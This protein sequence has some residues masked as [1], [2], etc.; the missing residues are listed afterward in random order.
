MKAY[1]DSGGITPFI[2]NIRDP[3]PLLPRMNQITH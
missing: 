2:L 3:V 1:R